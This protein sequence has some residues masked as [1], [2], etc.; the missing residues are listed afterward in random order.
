[1]RRTYEL[2]PRISFKPVILH[3]KCV[4]AWPVRLA[5]PGGLA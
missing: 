2:R 5:R 3:D 1:M 4:A